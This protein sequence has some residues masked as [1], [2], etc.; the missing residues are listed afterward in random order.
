MKILIVIANPKSAEALLGF[1]G[2]CSRAQQSYLCFFTGDGVKLLSDNTIIDA[3]KTAER[4]VA[5][6]YSWG[7]YFKSQEIPIEQGSQTDHS[8][9]ISMVDRVISL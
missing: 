1:C 2:A 9:M 5:C 7:K 8:S 6:E 4:N 3:I